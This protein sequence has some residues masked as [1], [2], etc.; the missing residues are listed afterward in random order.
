MKLKN[1]MLNWLG[2]RLPA[3]KEVTKLASEAMERSLS[4]RRRIALKLH[5][6]TCSLCMRY[7][8]QLQT[9]R[10]VAHQH[11]AKME[12]TKPAARLS[13]DARE[14]MKQALRT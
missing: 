1:E 14:R 3:C 2:R 4:L 12:T 9:M 8:Q 13:G 10:E 5:L 11:T 6:L 7:V